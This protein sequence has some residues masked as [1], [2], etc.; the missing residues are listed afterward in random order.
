MRITAILL[1][2]VASLSGTD[3]LTG[4]WRADLKASTLPAGFPKLR[5]QTMQ[6]E[7]AGD[8][9]RCVTE[10]V[11]IADVRTQ[12]E[13]T[14]AFD[15]KRYPV[16]GMQEISNVSLHRYPDFIEAD[17]FSGQKPVFSYRMWA[18]NKGDTLTI[19]SIE[20]TTRAELHARILYHRA[21]A[22]H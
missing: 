2:V 10:R 15:G 5:S 9:L 7:Q 19:I 11:T 14:A 20:P 4:N 3:G 21:P 13:F 8:K 1:L 18:S 22:I 17:F 12:A 16:T 6:L